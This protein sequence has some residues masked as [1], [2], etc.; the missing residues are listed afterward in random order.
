[1]GIYVKQPIPHEPIAAQSPEEMHS[2]LVNF[3]KAKADSI[4][5]L[6]SNIERELNRLDAIE[7]LDPEIREDIGEARH[8]ITVTNAHSVRGNMKA[9]IHAA[10]YLG[11]VYERMGIRPFEEL[12]DKAKANKIGGKKGHVARYGTPE[13]RKKLALEIQA[14]VNRQMGEKKTNAIAAA[15][16]HFECSERTIWTYLKK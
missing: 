2:I 5:N 15:A 7:S 6:L 14:F 8:Y 10:F 9:V 3:A 1:M 12:V 13:D 16:R 11:R 4:E